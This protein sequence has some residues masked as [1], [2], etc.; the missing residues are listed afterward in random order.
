MA[1]SSAI[2]FARSAGAPGIRVVEYTI[3]PRYISITWSASK[4]VFTSPGRKIIPG[5]LHACQESRSIAQQHYQLSFGASPETT[6]IYFNPEIEI[7]RFIWA[8]LGVSPSLGQKLSLEDRDALQFFIGV[9]CDKYNLQVGEKF[10]ED[11]MYYYLGELDCREVE[12]TEKWP[13]L[14]CLRTAPE[15]EPVCSRHWWFDM[16]NERAACLQSEKWPKAMAKCLELTKEEDTVDEADL[17]SYMTLLTGNRQ[18]ALIDST[19]DDGMDSE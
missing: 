13:E 10:G 17:F 7:V 1:K 14:A 2:R 12:G 18:M 9:M 16:W 4:R 6:R 8:S 11:D 15:E 3:K 19:V 5:L